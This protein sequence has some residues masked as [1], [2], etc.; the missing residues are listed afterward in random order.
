MLKSKRFNFLRPESRRKAIVTIADVARQAGVATST[1]SYVLSGKRSI[2]GATRDRV[3]EAVRVLGYRPNASARALASSRSNVLALVI[4]LRAGMHVPV[5]M[6]FATAVVTTARRFDH[7][8]LLLTADEGRSGL[9]R[10]SQ[11]ALVDALVVM[12]VELHDERVPLL[13]ELPMPSVLIGIPADTEGLTCIDLDFFAAAEQCVDHLTDL[14]HREIALLGTPSAVYERQ[15]GFAARTM[16]GFQA[17]AERR[18]IQGIETPC[19][20]TFD[21]VLGTVGELLREHPGITGLVVQNEPI[22]G[23]LLDVLRSLGRRVP[24]DMSLLAIC[25]DDVAERQVPKLSS[26][27]LPA[28]EIGQQAVEALI[29]KLDGNQAPAVTLVP[30]QL[31]ARASTST[32]P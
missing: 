32:A 20:S 18:G 15:T 9:E 28:D 7:D 16:A 1:V 26:V 27:T 3:Q 5:L 11:S 13:R 21:A 2:S 6:Q 29:A 14:G 10:V 25:A 4:P 12:D 22:I 23:P 19:E 8:V 24:E 30:A 17:A 31:T